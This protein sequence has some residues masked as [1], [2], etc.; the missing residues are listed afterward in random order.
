[1][2]SPDVL[3]QARKIDTSQPLTDLV[4]IEQEPNSASGALLDYGVPALLISSGV[5]WYLVRNEKRLIEQVHDRVRLT[6][7]KRFDKD[8]QVSREVSQG[9]TDMLS[10]EESGCV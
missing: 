3:E 9:V 4:E 8:E 6:V 1:M 5:L 10:M 7:E 2:M